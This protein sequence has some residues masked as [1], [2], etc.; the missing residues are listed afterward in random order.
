MV[1]C[2]TYCISCSYFT[3]SPQRVRLFP[4][5]WGEKCDVLDWEAFWHPSWKHLG[6]SGLCTRVRVCM[7]V[8]PS[9]Q[10]WACPAVCAPWDLSSQLP[11]T[12]CSW[13]SSFLQYLLPAWA[14]TQPWIHL[15]IDTSHQISHVQEFSVWH[16]LHLGILDISDILIN[17]FKT[18]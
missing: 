3:C 10:K 14:S 18:C 15:L 7:H 17:I 2:S 9:C 6:R 11:T 8:G 1:H 13:S 16:A 12:T 5:V 4:V